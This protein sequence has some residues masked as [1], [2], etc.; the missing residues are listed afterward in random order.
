MAGAVQALGQGQPDQEAAILG[1][2]C[3]FPHRTAYLHRA[4]SQV[5]TFLLLLLVQFSRQVDFLTAQC[6]KLKSK[7]KPVGLT[8]K[9]IF[10]LCVWLMPESLHVGL[11]AV[12][13]ESRSCP[14]IHAGFAV[15]FLTLQFDLCFIWM[16]FIYPLTSKVSW[17]QQ[18]MHRLFPYPVLTVK[19]IPK[20][21][22]ASVTGGLYWL[23]DIRHPVNNTVPESAFETL[24][25]QK[26]SSEVK[27]D[28]Y[29]D[30]KEHSIFITGCSVSVWATLHIW[31]HWRE[32]SII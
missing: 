12:W 32:R 6:K 16:L 14:V 18:C 3:P 23:T 8:K 2:D 27:R 26:F 11:T 13:Q 30:V 25:I 9:Q 19:L 20:C 24:W 10:T 5:S 31:F 1:W 22:C 17:H 15:V 21:R 29:S 28:S 4:V 7:T